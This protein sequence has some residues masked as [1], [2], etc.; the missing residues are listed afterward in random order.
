MVGKLT[1]PVE[2]EAMSGFRYSAEPRA[3]GS[4]PRP[5]VEN[6]TIIPGQRFSTPAFT[7]ANRAGSEDELSSS[8]RTWIWTRVAPASKAACVLSI[9]SGDVTGR[10][11]LSF[12]RGTDPVMATA[13]T[14]GFMA[15]PPRIGAGSV[16]LLGGFLP[17]RAARVG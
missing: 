9:C 11:G 10:A 4:R 14:T 13:M 12:L 8:L 6:C 2:S 16:A 1:E 15:G 3:D 5:P 17:R 7:A